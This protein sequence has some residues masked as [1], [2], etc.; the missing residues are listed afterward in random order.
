MGEALGEKE[1][2][3]ETLREVATGLRRPVCPQWEVPG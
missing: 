1:A 3:R 2:S